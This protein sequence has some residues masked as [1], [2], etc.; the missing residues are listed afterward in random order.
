VRDSVPE[1]HL[2]H[3]V[4]DMAMEEPDLSA[5][6]AAWGEERGFPPYRPAM[7]TA[8]PPY[9]TCRGVHSSRRLEKACGERVDFMA[10]TGMSKP[11][12]ACIREFR[13][14][15]RVALQGLFVQVLRVG[16]EAGPARPGHVSLDGDEGE[17]EPARG[18]ELRADAGDGAEAAGGGG[19]V[20]AGSGGGGRPGG[21]GPDAG[22]GG[23]APGGSTRGR[24][25]RTAATARRRTCGAWRS[26]GSVDAWR[27]GDRSTERRRRRTTAARGRGPAG[28]GS[29]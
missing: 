13:R 24:R 23:G 29:A 16:R 1:G 27:R 21:T 20:V 8:L 6:Y 28:W 9:G 18:D 19:G 10:V 22:G 25:R 17:R 5:P 7:M 4:R 14:R 15:H 3:F 2:A 12:P 26:E 11:D